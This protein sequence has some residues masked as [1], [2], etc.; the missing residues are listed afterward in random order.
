MS[1]NKCALNFLVFLVACFTEDQHIWFHTLAKN[2][3]K[4]PGQSN[5]D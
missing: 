3:Q 2:L 5:F 4:M 1:I